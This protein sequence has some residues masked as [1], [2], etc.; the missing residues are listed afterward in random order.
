MGG[1]KISLASTCLGR[2]LSAQPTPT[3]IIGVGPFECT[4][5]Q[6]IS[7]SRISCVIRPGFGAMHA[8]ALLVGAAKRVIPCAKSEPGPSRCTFHYRLPTI[9]S[10][11][12]SLMHWRRA[13]TDYYRQGFRASPE[14]AL[15]HPPRH[16]RRPAVHFGQDIGVPELRLKRRRPHNLRTPA[17]HPQR[18]DT[19]HHQTNHLCCR[20]SRLQR[21]P[22]WTRRKKILNLRWDELPVRRRDPRWRRLA[23]ELVGQT[24]LVDVQP[25]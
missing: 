17:K 8:M 10:N 2:A 21:L 13:H 4:N 5:A 1:V 7:P 3:F 12:P 14:L 19:R 6:I 9:L 16:C 25:H 24:R 15:P 20:L 22:V 23:H 11:Y 18:F